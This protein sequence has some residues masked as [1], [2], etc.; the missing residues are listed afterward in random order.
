MRGIPFQ[1]VGRP[2]AEAK[3]DAQGAPAKAASEGAGADATPQP[4]E[5]AIRSALGEVVAPMIERLTALEARLSNPGRPE[6]EEAAQDEIGE[7]EYY[8]DPMRSTRQIAEQV[9]SRTFEERGKLPADL[10]LRSAVRLGIDAMSSRDELVPGFRDEFESYISNVDPRAL[11]AEYQ[12]PRDKNKRISGLD[13]AWMTFKGMNFDRMREGPA[14]IEEEASPRRE[15]PRVPFSESPSNRGERRA[16]S[17]GLSDEQ[18]KVAKRLG[19]SEEAYLAEMKAVSEGRQ[20]SVDLA[21]R[22]KPS[23]NPEE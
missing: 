20:T 12:D 14:R 2:A 21:P 8:K 11:V 5:Q 18:R 1:Q 9:A 17:G 16:R 22:G 15:R 13:M 23:R 3:V 4:M 7:A 6:A 19:I 10:A